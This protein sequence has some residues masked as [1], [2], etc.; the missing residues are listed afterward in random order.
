MITAKN[1]APATGLPVVEVPCLGNTL[2]LCF[3]ECARRGVE[4]PKLKED[5]AKIVEGASTDDI[6]HIAE[7][8]CAW[9]IWLI[10]EYLGD[11]GPRFKQHKE[12]KYLKFNT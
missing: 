7:K 9:I 4:G 11:N 3:P 12:G 6:L 8:L 5:V 10:H 1:K 2:T